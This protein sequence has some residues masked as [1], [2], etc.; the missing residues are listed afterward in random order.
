MAQ[1]R[2]LSLTDSQRQELLH[3]RD[4]MRAR[5]CVNAVRRC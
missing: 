1:R 4:Q 2:T 3:A 5:M